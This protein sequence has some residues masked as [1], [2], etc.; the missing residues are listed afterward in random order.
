MPLDGVVRRQELVYQHREAVPRILIDSGVIIPAA[1]RAHHVLLPYRP[2]LAWHPLLS[3]LA[4]R[5]IPG[6][7]VV[8]GDTYRRTI[9]VAGQRGHIEVSREPSRHALALRAWLPEPRLLPTVVEKVSHI[10]DLAA[11]PRV[12]AAHLGVDEVLAPRV[13]RLPGLRVPGAWD[14]FELGVRAILGQQVT[15]KGASTLAG[16]LVTMCGRPVASASAGLSH[17]FPR[18]ADLAAADLSTLGV[19]R[20]RRVSLQTLATAL[21][22]G[23]LSFS[24]QSVEAA[25]DALPGVGAWTVQYVLMRACGDPDAFPASDLWL[26]RSSGASST[27]ALIARAEAWRP[28]RAYAAMYLWQAG[29]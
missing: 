3:F 1:L 18:P 17:L 27:S 10:F 15:V 24:G 12:I 29:A 9:E 5:A 23:R 7:E 19:P 2:P 13:R 14:G 21:A 11:D 22:D 20:Q 26:R 8:T 4:A 28:F 6:V 16:R 25:L